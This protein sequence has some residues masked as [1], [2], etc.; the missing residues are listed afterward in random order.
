MA[1][2]LVT[3]AVLTTVLRRTWEDPA[4]AAMPRARLIGTTVRLSCAAWTT[5]RPI[6]LEDDHD[7]SDQLSRPAAAD[8]PQPV[9]TVPVAAVSRRF[10]LLL[11]TRGRRSGQPR[12]TPLTSMPPG[13]RLAPV[14]ASRAELALAGPD[15]AAVPNSNHSRAA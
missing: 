13:E 3:N 15:P 9:P 12:T 5:P 7:P 8:R 1:T 11:T 4:V 14:L 2:G 10:V 6:G